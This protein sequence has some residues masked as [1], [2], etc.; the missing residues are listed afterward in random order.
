MLTTL[1]LKLFYAALVV[2]NL[3][4]GCRPEQKSQDFDWPRSGFKARYAFR[5][6]DK[7]DECSGAVPWTDSTFL[8][9]NDDGPAE[10]YE[11]NYAG[12]LVST[13]PVP[14]AVNHDWEDLA[15]DSA[16]TLYISDL[17]NNFNIRKDLAVYR[18]RP[19]TAGAERIGVRYQNQTDYAPTKKG[20]NFD[21]EALFYWEGSLYAL[22]KNRGRKTV[23]AYRIPDQPGDQVAV[24]VDSARLFHAVT[25]AAVSPDGQLLGVVAYGMVYLFRLV[26][27]DGPLSHPL[28]CLRFS[29]SGQSEAIWWRDQAHLYIANEAQRVFCFERL[30]DGDF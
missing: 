26:T 30:N 22:S 6:P 13:K 10:L 4:C 3:F 9:L 19:G 18:L 27:G 15:R 17:G 25:G 1:Q 5:L 28:A 14:G 24:P 29:R 2:Q 7:V 21:G 8:T 23:I 11:V 16:G 12:R 20:L